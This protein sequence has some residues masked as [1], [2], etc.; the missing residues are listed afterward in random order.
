MALD[1]GAGP[2]QVSRDHAPRERNGVCL[3]DIRGSAHGFQHHRECGSMPQAFAAAI[4]SVF[5][6]PPDAVGKSPWRRAAIWNGAHAV[7]VVFG[8][9]S[10]RRLGL[11]IGGSKMS[12]LEDVIDGCGLVREGDVLCA[13]PYS[14][15]TPQERDWVIEELIPEEADQPSSFATPTP[16]AWPPTTPGVSSPS[17]RKSAIIRPPARRSS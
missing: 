12:I 10:Y 16:A 3:Q 7:I 11:V 6:V 9:D 2:D 5:A 13:R 8:C 14:R 1:L 17:S 15:L 4:R